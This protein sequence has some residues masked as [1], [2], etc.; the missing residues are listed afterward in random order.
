MQ[1]LVLSDAEKKILNDRLQMD[2]CL[3][4]VV[5]DTFEEGTYDPEHVSMICNLLH[6]G[7]YDKAIEEDKELAV[8][9]LADAVNGSTW[10]AQTH[11]LIQDGAP[12]I[13]LTTA[14]RTGERLAD[15]VQEYLLQFDSEVVVS[16]PRY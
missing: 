11:N 15:K 1:R 4:D 3:N 2:D 8:F 12:Q 16:F 10:A 7:E 14:I 5:Q 6:K 13:V 9:I